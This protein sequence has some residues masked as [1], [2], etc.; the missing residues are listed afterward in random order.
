MITLAYAAAAS[1][2][3]ASA[4]AVAAAIRRHYERFSSLLR[5]AHDARARYA[6]AD[7]AARIC[8]CY[9]FDVSPADADYYYTLACRR[10][11]L[12]MLR[13]CAERSMRCHRYHDDIRWRWREQRG[14]RRGAHTLF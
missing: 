3:A 10:Y 8:C 2:A 1:A 7:A 4:A 11:G 5:R 9:F 14:S 12:M 6:D 13:G